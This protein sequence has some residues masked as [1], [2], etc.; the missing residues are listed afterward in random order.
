[1]VGYEIRF[2]K[3][4]E[5][6]IDGDAVSHRVRNVLAEN[7]FRNG[8]D[9]LSRKVAIVDGRVAGCENEFPLRVLVFGKTYEAGSGNSTTIERWARRSGI[10]LVISDFDSEGRDWDC[11]ILMGGALSQI[12]VKVHKFS[13]YT[14]FEFPRFIFPLRSRAVVESAVKGP[15]LWLVSHLIDFG[16]CLYSL[17]V[18]FIAWCKTYGCNVD[19]VSCCDAKS[20][21]ELAGLVC[22][23]VKPCREI[24]NEEWFKWVMTT[25]FSMQEPCTAF[26]V[27]HES[28][29]LGFF[30]VKRRFHEQA[31][32]RGFKNVWLTSVVEWGAHDGHEK[33]IYW[34]I[35]KYLFDRSRGDDAVEFATNDERLSSLLRHLMWRQVGNANF[36][37]KIREGSALEQY[38]E[39]M[40]SIG[41]W[42]VRPAYGDYA[43]S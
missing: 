30:M 39:E 28:R 22:A 14:V 9:V 16:I 2:R 8:R 11:P 35:V 31:S 25:T 5:L 36:C 1:M 4:S 33:T 10:G 17:M 34:A 15:L 41:N 12:A 43:L 42:R 24:H 21:G 13:G 6:G 18:R 40:S 32:S 20:L 27:R 26:V 29:V 38:A 19:K 7:P 23:D 37:F 3:L